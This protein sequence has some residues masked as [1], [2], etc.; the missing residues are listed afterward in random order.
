M[1]M[2]P[3]RMLTNMRVKRAAAYVLLYVS[4]MEVSENMCPA[5]TIIECSLSFFLIR[6][7]NRA[8]KPTEL[9]ARQR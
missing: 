2:L 4:S 6:F 1:R 5:K 7:L 9:L 3:K 8:L